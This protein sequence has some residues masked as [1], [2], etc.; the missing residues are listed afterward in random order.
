M[1]KKEEVLGKI[2]TDE[3]YLSP[4]V[5]LILFIILIGVVSLIGFFVMGGLKSGEHIDSSVFVKVSMGPSDRYS[6]TIEIKNTNTYPSD[7]E[8]SSRGL[9]GMI[10][11]SETSFQLDSEG[12]KELNFIFDDLEDYPSGIYSGLIV[13]SSESGEDLIPVIL[14]LQGSSA[15]IK[16]VITLIPASQVEPGGKIIA[17]MKI[18]DLGGL[19]PVESSIEYGLLNFEGEKVLVLSEEVEIIDKLSLMRFVDVDSGLDR[20]EYVFFLTVNYDG[21]ASAS[22][23]IVSV[24]S[25]GFFSLFGEN[26]LYF[27]ILLIVFLVFFLIFVLY[28]ENSQEEIIQR[29][30]EQYRQELSSQVD[31]LKLKQK[32]NEASLKTSEE[33]ALNKKYFENLIDKVKI[34]AS[35]VREVRVA[36]VKELSGNRK[37]N[38]EALMRQKLSKWKKEGY[39]MPSSLKK[40]IPSV[41]KIKKEVKS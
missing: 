23:S 26:Q 10:S 33:R 12:T 1:N 31:Y 30:R 37:E 34:Q 5:I 7:Y 13:I 11:F 35:T 21:G 27:F 36:E 17:D 4:W 32:Q 20:G 22:S 16:G 8:V 14:E 6:E 41:D 38:K 15:D 19:S 3:K 25:E 40:L 39:E 28:N 2:K 24:D 9:D 18:Y 29:L